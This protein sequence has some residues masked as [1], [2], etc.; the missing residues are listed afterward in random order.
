[1]TF[2]ELQSAFELEINKIDA[3][4]EKPK[5]IDTEYW[6]NKGLERFYKTRYSGTNSNGYSFEQ[7]QKRIDDLRTLVVNATLPVSEKSGNAF[8]AELPDNYV[9]L[10]GDTVSIVPADGIT[11]NCWP[12]GKDNKYIPYKSDTLEA[13]VET[14]DRQLENSL[15]EHNLK[16]CKAKPL[17]L[18]QGK[19]V[20][21][22]TDGSY[23]PSTYSIT[24]LK[25]PS[26]I[27]LHTNPRSEFNE[28]PA[29]THSEIVM[30]AVQMYLEN[31]A[32]NRYQ[33][34][35]NEVSIME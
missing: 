23:K 19:N 32:N 20:I 35:T 21:L 5:S 10:L 33:T 1:M 15:S 17:R 27:D 22:Y 18:I 13:T 6:L 8:S 26:K 12:L 16:Y 28:M 25:K 30:L 24:Y 11:N 2:I 14:I 7:N 9:F 3:N 31:Q 4:L 29:H 34:Y